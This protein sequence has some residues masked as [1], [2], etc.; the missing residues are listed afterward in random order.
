MDKVLVNALHPHLKAINIT[1]RGDEKQVAFFTARDFI[2]SLCGARCGDQRYTQQQSTV[3]TPGWRF[4]PR[5][6]RNT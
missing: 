2:A 6:L 4:T 1:V 5:G 3:A